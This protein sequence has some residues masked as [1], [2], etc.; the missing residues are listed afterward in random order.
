MPV[1]VSAHG[2]E[3]L[4]NKDVPGYAFI[5]DVPARIQGWMCFC[6]HK[7]NLSNSPDSQ[8]TTKCMS[9]GRRS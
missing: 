2:A 7:L 8:E 3:V 6:G 5:Y 4:V 9:C 1:E